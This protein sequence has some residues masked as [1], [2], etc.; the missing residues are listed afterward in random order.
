MVSSVISRESDGKG[1]DQKNRDKPYQ[2]PLSTS[3]RGKLEPEDE[4]Y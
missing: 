2:K 3:S 1:G 4:A